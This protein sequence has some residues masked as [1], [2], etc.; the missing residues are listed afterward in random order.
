M[1]LVIH[2]IPH[3]TDGRDRTDL[4]GDSH[5]AD[6]LL[7][8]AVPD[9]SLATIFSMLEMDVKPLVQGLLERF[10]VD[11]GV[12]VD[13]AV[14]LS[15]QGDGAVHGAGVKIEK[16]EILGNELGKGA[17]AGGGKAVD[18]DCDVRQCHD[19]RLV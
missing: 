10:K 14:L 8:A 17:L 9:E 4:A 12:G 3:E 19:K 2:E 16:A 5:G 13:H 1:K 7:H 15:E 18:S 11:I 6:V